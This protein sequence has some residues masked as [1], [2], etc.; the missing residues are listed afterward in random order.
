METIKEIERLLSAAESE[1]AK[2]DGK[3]QSILE[4][5]KNLK[6]KRELIYR[7]IPQSSSLYRNA[8]VTN[9]SSQE[10]RIHLFRTLFRGREDVYPQRFESLKTGKTGYQPACRNEWVKGLCTK[11][12]VKCN[13]CENREFLPVTDDVIRNHLIGSN[14]LVK[15]KRDFVIG[16]Y[17]LLPDESCWFLAADFDKT[18]W[19]EDVSEFLNTCKAYN[20]P[21]ALERSRSGNGGHIWIFFSEPVPAVLA[22]KMGAFILT[23]TM[24]R[25]PEIGLD[26]YDRF[27]PNQDTMPKGGFGSLIALPLQRKPR[28]IGNSVFLDEKLIP[29][30]DQWAFLSSLPRMHRYEI[31]TLVDEAVSRGR[32]VGVRM[33]VTEEDADEPWKMPPSR[34]RK[35]PP[36]G[37]SLPEKISMV[38]SNQVYIPKESL[39]PPL[40]NRLIRLA[41][42]QNPEFYKAQAM[43]LPTFNKP[44]IICCC[45]DF[46]RHIGIPRGCLEEVVELLQSLNIKPEVVD[47]RFSGTQIKLNFHGTLRPDQELAAKTML[48]HETG[49]L[50]ASTA[51]GKTIVATYLIAQ[52]NANTLVLVHRRQLLDQWISR[53]SHFLNLDPKKIGQIGGGKRNP[54][55]VIDVALIQS[56]SRKVI[57]DDI[58]GDYG[59]LVVDEC[60]HIPA[61]SFEMVTGQCKAR[62]VTGLSATVTRKDGHHPIIFMQCGPVRYRVEDRKQAAVRPFRHRVIVRNTDF[63]LPDSLINRDAPLSIHELYSALVSDEGRN[64]MIVDDVLEAVRSK[65]SPVLL[66]E[67]RDHLELLV[68]RLSYLIR[69]VIVLRGG[70]R[71]KQRDQI[72]ERIAGIPDEEE[73]IIVATGRYLGEGFDDARLDTLFLALPVSWRGTIAQYAGRLHRSHEN[74][75][76]VVIYDYADLEVPMLAKMHE[77]RRGGYKA[78]GYEIDQ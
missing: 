5:I 1:L 75:K 70:M 53:L 51:F 56:L 40:K 28:E 62:Y 41:A 16:V 6:S 37:G 38:L 25:R 59:H 72:A 64:D 35:E 12:K 77:R 47:E 68:E 15:S 4:H 54:T 29:Y 66:T 39:S 63:R 2:L 10:E 9:Q 55:G 50:S 58:V 17:L 46:S 78:I 45:E 19:M 48:N 24:E 36:I 65:R 30:L 57:V 61:R 71:Q 73:R 8:P 31:E 23:E 3:R 13:D 11:P 18:T 32:V 60:H 44:R 67:R 27:F 33:A 52:R 42:F 22:R 43:R 21:A 7:G 20:I 26:S 49:V 76:E 74:K 69:N 34:R 14:P